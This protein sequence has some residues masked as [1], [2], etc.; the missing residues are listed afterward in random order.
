MSSRQ[1]EFWAEAGNCQC[2]CGFGE[3]HDLQGVR[4]HIGVEDVLGQHLVVLQCLEVGEMG[5]NY[6]GN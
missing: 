6:K 2:S 5:K 1:L 4:V 3:L